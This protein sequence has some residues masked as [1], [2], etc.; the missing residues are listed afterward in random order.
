[1]RRHRPLISILLGLVLLAQGF[2]VSAAPR[3]IPVAKHGGAG[4]SAMAH[5]PC[6]MMK[7][8][9]PVKQKPSCCNEVC[10][11]MTTCALGTLATVA[12][13]SV[14]VQKGSM[15]VPFLRVISASRQAPTSLLRPPITLHG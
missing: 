6:H 9:R 3:G 11:D 7:A 15:V 10:P 8:E 2:A 13:L 12:P 1:M 5:M 14:A 4:M